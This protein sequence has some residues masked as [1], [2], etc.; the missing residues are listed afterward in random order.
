[1]TVN[2]KPADMTAEMQFEGGNIPA[3]Y[4]IRLVWL[5]IA[6]LIVDRKKYQRDPAAMKK[7]KDRAD[8]WSWVMC[9]F[10]T[11]MVRQT[12][13]QYNVDGQQRALSA[14]LRGITHLPCMVSSSDGPAAEALVFLAINRDRTAVMRA[15]VF[16]AEVGARQEPQVSIDA[17]I[18]K[19]GMEISYT[20]GGTPNKVAA[21]GAIIKAWK[22]NEPAA[23][24]AIAAGA[25]LSKKVYLTLTAFNGLYG[26]AET[27]VD[28][29]KHVPK[30]LREGGV[31]R[32]HQVAKEMSARNNL[33]ASNKLNA[34]AAVK[35]MINSK[36][37]TNRL[38]E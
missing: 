15:G 26:L 35:K 9:G 21:M 30:L 13:K 37:T 28:V 25:A 14:E 17:W 11:V 32:I 38:P 22:A 7:I 27:G 34:T 19:C 33:P 36:C 12:E 23:R 3:D 6:D 20:G 24:N 16:K 31:A 1:M 8:N 4:N 2:K 18:R 5:P 10:L 29:V